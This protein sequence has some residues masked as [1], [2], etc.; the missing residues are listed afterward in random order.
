MVI[1]E[2]AVAITVVVVLGLEI[3][4]GNSGHGRQASLKSLLLGS[5]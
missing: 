2:V 1:T 5:Q 4:D 3:D